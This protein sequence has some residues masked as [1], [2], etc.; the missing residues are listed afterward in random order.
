[1]DAYSHLAATDRVGHGPGPLLAWNPADDDLLPRTAAAPPPAPAPVPAAPVAYTAP[2]GAAPPPVGVTYPAY[3]APPAYPAAD[4]SLLPPR[5]VVPGPARR[6]AGR[7]HRLSR[8]GRAETGRGGGRLRRF[9]RGRDTGAY[10]YPYADALPQYTTPPPAVPGAVL[11]APLAPAPAPLVPMAPPPPQYPAAQYPPP[12][13]YPAPPQ[14]H[15][16]P[17]PPVA[18]ASQQY[19][20]FPPATPRFPVAP[21]PAPLPAAAPPPAPAPA[22]APAVAPEELLLAPAA[23]VKIDADFWRRSLAPLRDFEDMR[24]LP[25]VPSFDGFD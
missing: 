25:D 1:M 6:G 4:P 12:P 5:T 19:A 15:P 7:G 8:R 23:E 3:P 18:P 16:A 22:P 24:S 13:Q 10:E 2:V 14:Q 11:P 17:A 9:G 20:P 21:A